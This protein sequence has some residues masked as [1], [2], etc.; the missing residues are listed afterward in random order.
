[1]TDL[2]DWT[3]SGDESQEAMLKHA[4][5][6]IA[7]L[8]KGNSLEAL[9]IIHDLNK[10]RDQRLFAE[11]GRMTRTL[12]DAIV[13]FHNDT[14]FNASDKEELSRIR[15][16]SDRLSYV[17]QMTEKAANKT[18]DMIE[19][20]IPMVENME[21]NARYLKPEWERL[22]RREMKPEEFRDLYKKMDVFLLNTIEESQKLKLMYSDILMAQDYQD[23]T[24][25]IIKRVITLV[26]EVEESLVKLVRMAV[27]VDAAA[28]ISHQLSARQLSERDKLEGPNVGTVKIKDAVSGQD[29]VDDLLSSLGF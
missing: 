7:Q 3:D 23:L 5:E 26:K 8:E 11:V 15:D 17:I 4:K 9:N 28:G 24:G 29:E 6:L 1:M 21:M 22:M 2:T 10:Y 20:T 14:N 19:Q 12:H 16:A 18:M 27:Q 25:Q 13:N